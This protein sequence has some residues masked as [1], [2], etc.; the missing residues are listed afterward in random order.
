MTWARPDRERQARSKQSCR[1]WRPKCA[2]QSNPSPDRA[3]NSVEK[4]DFLQVG[5]SV[6][7]KQTNFQGIVR[8]LFETGDALVE[9]PGRPEEQERVPLEQL[10]LAGRDGLA[11]GQHVV[12]RGCDE[13]L[14]RGSVGVLVCFRDEGMASVRMRG[15]RFGFP[16]EELLLAGDEGQL[17][18]GDWVLWA[19]TD[20]DIPEGTL[21]RVIG[22]DPLCGAIVSEFPEGGR[23]FG[24]AAQQLQL[25]QRCSLED[26]PE[27]SSSC[28]TDPPPCPATPN[29]PPC[30]PFDGAHE[31]EFPGGTIFA[32]LTSGTPPINGVVVFCPGIH[33]GVG[34]C[35]TPGT[36]YDPDALFPTLA[37]QLRRE[38][39]VSCRVCWSA[40]HPPL[41]E[42]IGGVAFAVRY[43]LRHVCDISET[44]PERMGLCLVGHSLGGAVVLGAARALRAVLPD[45]HARIG[46]PR[47]DVVAVCTLAA[48]EKGSV[49]A[50][51]DLGGV[52]KLFFHGTD[53]A[54][55]PM[56]SARSIHAAAPR[57]KEL[58]ILPGAEHDF[59]TW[60]AHLLRRIS[61]FLASALRHCSSETRSP[62]PRLSKPALR[63]KK[64]WR[65]K[66]TT[67]AL[68]TKAPI[69]SG[70]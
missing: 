27:D 58:R 19:E 34:P 66:E 39:V 47:A 53:D 63:H 48:Q 2:D 9:F 6:S 35:R 41:E 69:T 68:S 45:W 57:P 11:V 10:R 21:G 7:H 23:M 64:V 22:H 31:I 44:N 67:A 36:N 25:V 51:K 5:D 13:E 12:W 37:G 16:V 65:I 49:E 28:G 52:R 33:G 3:P 61:K 24:F 50:V 42:A 62:I 17:R 29:R 26:V 8:A 70:R 40:M 59:Y 15:G 18:S 4:L 38:G 46:A 1:V 32:A 43:A 14:P 54:V 20:E 56:D 55:L 30:Y 60:K